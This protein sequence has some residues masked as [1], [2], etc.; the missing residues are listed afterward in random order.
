M[1]FLLNVLS[2][3]AGFSIVS[4]SFILRCESNDIRLDSLL[5]GMGALSLAFVVFSSGLKLFE[6]DFFY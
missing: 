2:R 4:S 5:D 3:N 1:R 6:K